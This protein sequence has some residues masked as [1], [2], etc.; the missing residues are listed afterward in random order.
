MY[1]MTVPFIL[2]SGVLKEEPEQLGRQA[3]RRDGCDGLEES[4][5]QVRGAVYA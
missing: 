1:V 5:S 2:A 4:V 3:A